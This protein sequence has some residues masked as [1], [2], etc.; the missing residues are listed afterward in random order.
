MVTQTERK[1]NQYA[2]TLWGLPRLLLSVTYVSTNQLYACW[3]YKQYPK[4]ITIM[5][6]PILSRYSRMY[7]RKYDNMYKTFHSNCLYDMLFSE[8]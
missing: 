2:Y 1:L 8:V 5:Q 3:Q 6:S 4:S 7:R